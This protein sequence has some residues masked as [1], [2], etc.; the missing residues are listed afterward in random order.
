MEI[1]IDTSVIYTD[2]YWKRNFPGQIIDAAKNGQLNIYFS[3]VVLRELRRNFEKQI[4]KELLVIAAA[5]SN[6]NKLSQRHK[7]IEIPKK[8]IYLAE[9]DEY[10]NDFFKHKNIILL[11][12][13]DNI[14]NE[15][16]EK[17]I[18]RIKPFTDTRNEFKDA[19]IWTTYYRY[20]KEKGLNNCHLLTNN[21]KD[22]TDTEG[23]LHKELLSDYDKFKVHL[24]LDEF[25]KANK[26]VIDKPIIEFQNWIEKQTINEEYV[27]DLLNDNETG[28]V[29]EEVRRKFKNA[30]PTTFVDDREFPNVF[31]GYVDIE[32]VHWYDCTDIEI[33]IINDYAIISGTLELT[34]EFEL[35]G[36]N[37]VRDAGDEKNPHYGSV[38]K[39]VEVYFNFRFDRD[40]MPK[41]FEVTGVK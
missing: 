34:V 5:N 4:E 28:K 15:L 7:T 27:F 38:D 33:D 26:E 9:F 31:G 18:H 16:L 32:D 10:Y 12:T 37:S 6:V 35:Y 36:Y 22:F 39:E 3:D 8:E 25:Y 29:F 41:N 40:K 14:L 17:A 21:K 1:F 20:A 24:T 2:P 23:N 30:D 11:K 19:A 13:E